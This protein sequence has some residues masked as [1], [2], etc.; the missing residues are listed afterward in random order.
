[1]KILLSSIALIFSCTIK[2][3]NDGKIIPVN[4]TIVCKKEKPKRKPTD[5]RYHQQRFKD[6]KEIT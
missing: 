1:M 4:M 5:W 6:D 3:A 2:T